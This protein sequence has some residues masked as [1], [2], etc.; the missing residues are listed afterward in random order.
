V[1]K[2]SVMRI[3][4]AKMLV[5]QGCMTTWDHRPYKLEMCNTSRMFE[6]TKIHRTRTP[7]K[8]RDQEKLFLMRNLVCI[9]ME[10]CKRGKDGGTSCSET[11]LHP[12]KNQNQPYLIKTKW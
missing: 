11:T 8:D 5:K 2:N 1:Q 3:V 4:V 9:A 6:D 7:C 12:P 10:Q